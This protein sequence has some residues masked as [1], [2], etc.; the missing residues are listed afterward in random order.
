MNNQF[1]QAEHCP[2]AFPQEYHKLNGWKY[3]FRLQGLKEGVYDSENKFCRFLN[4]IHE[5]KLLL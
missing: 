4:E 1:Y 3:I 2:N 5:S